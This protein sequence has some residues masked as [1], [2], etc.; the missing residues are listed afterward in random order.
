MRKWKIGAGLG[1]ALG[2][3]VAPSALAGITGT[4][5]DAIVLGSPPSSLLL[6]ALTDDDFGFIFEERTNYSLS[7][8]LDVDLTMA[9]TYDETDDLDRTRVQ[10]GTLVNSYFIHVDNDRNQP[11]SGKVKLSVTFDTPI[12]GIMVRDSTLD[13]SDGQLGAAGTIYP[14]GQRR[15]SYEF[16]PDRIIVSAD[17]RTVTIRTVSKNDMDEIRILTQVPEPASLAL[18]GLGA[19]AALFRRR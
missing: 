16:T 9:G 18:V 5:G 6:N 17:L 10:A 13:A 4:L 1:F 19:A 2:L 14:T 11:G 15:R 3:A 8:G 7:P 12:I